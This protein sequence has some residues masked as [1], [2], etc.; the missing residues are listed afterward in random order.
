MMKRA[1]ARW[2]ELWQGGLPPRSLA[3]FAFALVCV[4]IATIVR[5]AIGEI[6]PASAVFAPYYSATLVAALVGGWRAAAP[7]S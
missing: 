3:S 1:L 2:R 5:M 7:L 6:S 4:A